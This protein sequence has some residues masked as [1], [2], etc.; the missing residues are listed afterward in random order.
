MISTIIG[1]RPEIIKMSRLIPLLD[2]NFDHRFVFSG[3][4]YSK[5]MVDIFFEQLK[6]R[7]PNHVLTPGKLEHKPMASSDYTYLLP[8]ISNEIRENNPD[9]VIVYGDTN[10]TLAAALAAQKFGKKIIHIEAGLR[11]FDERMSEELVRILVDHMSELLFVPTDLESMFLEKE[12][13]KNNKFVVG[14]TVVDA[15]LYYSDIAD[16]E[17]RILENIGLQKDEYAFATIH[18]AE[19]V[20]SPEKL[21]KILRAL[22]TLDKQVVIP[23]HPRHKKRLNEFGYNVPSNIKTIEPLG[24]IDALKIMKNAAY[25]LT[26]SGGVQEE[27]I[28]LKVPCI[29]L[30][31]TTE[32]WET[33][34]AGANF[35]TGIDPRLINYKA[36]MILGTDV[37]TKI[38]NIPNPYGDGKT[39]ERITNILLDK[40]K[41]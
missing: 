3:Q 33:V 7:Q 11:S 8:A 30:R 34:S 31:E 19:N 12:G 9:Y 16:K 14:N 1:T 35:L 37:K 38:Q 32:R 24:Y 20:D 28:T 10:S 40:L 13:I 26:D 27:A 21:I 5:E 41:K 2:K 4:H 36:K 39:S 18:R 15:C 6:V 25:V 23:M 22:A 29:T 17:S